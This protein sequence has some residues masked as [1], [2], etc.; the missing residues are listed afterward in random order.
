VS[1]TPERKARMQQLLEELWQL[2]EE[3]EEQM[4]T[5]NS[6]TTEVINNSNKTEVTNIINKV[7]NCDCIELVKKHEPIWDRDGFV[8]CLCGD[9][10]DWLSHFEALI[11]GEQK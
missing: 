9:E 11:K 5:N 6:S 3:I 8:A 2:D 10:T 1:D 4:T 7:V